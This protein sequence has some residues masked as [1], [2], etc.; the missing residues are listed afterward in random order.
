MRAAF[1]AELWDRPGQALAPFRAGEALLGPHRLLRVGGC[2]GAAAR[3]CALLQ[4]RRGVKRAA[5]AHV[6][7]RG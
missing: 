7:P 6:M 1:G 2:V 5:E 3:G 4:A